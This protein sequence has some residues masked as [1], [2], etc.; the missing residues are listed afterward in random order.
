[1]FLRSHTIW[2]QQTS[3]GPWSAFGGQLWIKLPVSPSSTLVDLLS[4]PS[5]W[6]VWKPQVAYSSLFLEPFPL[7]NVWGW[8]LDGSSEPMQVDSCIEKAGWW[9]DWD[10]SLQTSLK[11]LKTIMFNELQ[12]YGKMTEIARNPVRKTTPLWWKNTVLLRVTGPLRVRYVQNAYKIRIL[13]T[14][15][16][17]IKNCLKVTKVQVYFM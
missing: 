7:T 5:S 8:W 16:E 14:C 15:W 3:M 13:K 12:R 2:Q 10:W 6:T 1:M 4:A 9:R 11:Q 17:L